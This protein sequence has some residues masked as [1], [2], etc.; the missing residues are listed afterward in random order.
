[1]I[2]REKRKKKRKVVIR[3][4]KI[5]DVTFL[6]MLNR[7]NYEENMCLGNVLKIKIIEIIY[8]NIYEISQIKVECSEILF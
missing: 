3:I 2:R 1:M 7:M 6:N 4:S 5:I 8:K